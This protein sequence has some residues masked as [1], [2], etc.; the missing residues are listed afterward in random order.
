VSRSLP[1]DGKNELFHAKLV[2]KNISVKGMS[3]A[4]Q[5]YKM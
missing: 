4:I 5:N 2:F 3:T 1:F